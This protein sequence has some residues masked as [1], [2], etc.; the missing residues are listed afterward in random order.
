MSMKTDI[1]T[2]AVGMSIF[3][4][5]YDFLADTFLGTIYTFGNLNVAHYLNFNA[6]VSQAFSI[7]GGNWG[8][9]FL[10][11]TISLV[12]IEDMV[13]YPISVGLYIPQ[14]VSYVIAIFTYVYN[15]GTFPFNYIY[16]PI[17]S[18]ISIFVYT[19]IGISL[20]LSVFI[21]RN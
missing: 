12:W 5:I 8:F 14:L 4:I 21:W 9:S 11:Y 18:V 15:L 13:A 10:G 19:I 6:A 3:V 1:R 2:L 17:G 20:A 16:A 7:L